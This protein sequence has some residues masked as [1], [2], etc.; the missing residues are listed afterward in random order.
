LGAETFHLVSLRDVTWLE[1][2]A[3][4]RIPW[5]VHAFG[6]RQGGALKPNLSGQDS[7]K[8]ANCGFTP[9]SQL[10]GRLIQ[11]LR[12]EGFPLAAMRQTH[13]AAIYCVS[14]G[15]GL[16]RLQYQLA[17]NPLPDTEDSLHL[18]SGDAL[19]SNH[20][21]I[22]L[23]IRVADCMPVLM[24]DRERRAI[25]AVH[26]G[27]RGA[28]NRII[29]KTVGEMCRTFDSRPEKLVAAI[30]PSIRGCCYK[31]GQEVV[32]AFCG[33]FPAGE[34]FFRRVP[35]TPEESHM[36]LRYQVP[37]MNQ[38]PPGHRVE[39]QSKV[40]LDLAAVACYQLEHAGVPRDQ[41]Y[42]ADY[43]T[44]CRTDLFYSYR[45]EASLAGRMLAMI[46]MR[47]PR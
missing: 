3:F 13:S 10:P 46:G 38:A 31:V 17:G 39:E 26:A 19:I 6:T 5:L 4:A 30:G 9:A 20:P 28:L 15:S 22:L 11:A 34:N 1:C 24:V 43:C 36:A 45:K 18:R 42:V 41:I 25:A 35:A 12:A 37:F 29:E 21:G 23:S 8:N 40:H 33:R 16:G 2:G 14:Q 47:P 27:W 7:V 32:E 44:A